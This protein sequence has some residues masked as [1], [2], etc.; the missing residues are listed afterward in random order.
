MEAEETSEK[1]FTL[2]SSE[3]DPQPVKKPKK[4]KEKKQ[5]EKTTTKKDPPLLKEEVTINL[6]LHPRKILKWSIV[7][8]VVILA[9]FLGRLSV[10]DG[11][12]HSPIP[13]EIAEEVEVDT[14]PGFFSKISNFFSGLF[15]RSSE[16]NLTVT[17]ENGTMT[18]PENGTAPETEET[19]TSLPET[20]TQPETDTTPTEDQTQEETIIT[21][22]SAVELT[23]NDIRIDW[24]TTWG[25]V[26]HLEYSIKNNEEGVIKPEYFMM[27]MEGYGDYEK[28]V[29]LPYT[30]KEIPAHS[31]ASSMATIDSGF[32]YSELSCGD[33]TNVK[34]VLSLY[35][36]NDTL[37]DSYEKEFNLQGE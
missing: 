11:E 6:R 21:E 37:M 23:L 17:S 10:G 19:E 1:T 12:Q 3:E 2:E 26:T 5:T 7:V 14:G 4:Q 24:K 8:L 13:E 25:K 16:G 36:I 28:K 34:I 31:S 33:L 32:S 29:S 27:S 22:Y 18:P 15:S 9:F 20:D 30:S 35:D